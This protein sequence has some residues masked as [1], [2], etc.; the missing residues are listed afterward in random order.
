MT[1]SGT[2]GLTVLLVVMNATMFN[3]ALPTVARDLGLT[4]TAASWIVTGYSILFAISS[5]TYSRLTDFVPIRTLLMIG[6]VLLGIASVI[7]PLS[8]HF[9]GVLGAQLLQAIGAASAPG[10][11][12]VLVTRHIPTERRG[13]SMSVIISAASLGFGLGPIVGGA[14]TQ[15]FS[16]NSLFVVTALAMLTIPI[17]YRNL[18]EQPLPIFNLTDG[19]LSASTSPGCCSF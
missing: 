16:W 11:G 12:V 10:L 2:W 3:V 4:T 19:A 17:F 18:P 1:T 8:H 14:M 15:Y 7:G 13:K 9:Y 6:L 5:I